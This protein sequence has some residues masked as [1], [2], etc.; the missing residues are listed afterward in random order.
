MAQRATSL[1]P[2][3]SLFIVFFFLFLSLLSIEKRTCSSPIKRA[4]FLIFECL[5]LFLLSLFL[6]PPFSLPLSLSLS[7]SFFLPSFLSFFVCFLL[8]P[9][10]SL[11]F[12]FFLLCFCFMKR[13]T[14]RNGG[15]QTPWPNRLPNFRPEMAWARPVMMMMMMMMMTMMTMMMMMMMMMMTMMMKCDDE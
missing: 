5:P 14:Y 2:K 15:K 1:G 3:P 4:F 7:C 9:F 10:L 11:S 12:F 6:P 13:T 8:I